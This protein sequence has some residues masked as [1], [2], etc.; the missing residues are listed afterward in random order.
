MN[1]CV[2]YRKLR[3]RLLISGILAAQSA[4]YVQGA[5]AQT[6]NEEALSSEEEVLVLGSRRAGRDVINSAVPVDVISARDIERTGFTQTVELLQSLVPSFSTSKNSITDATDYVRPAQLRGLGPEHVLVLVNG[7][8]RHIS[9]VVHDN[10]Q[11]RGSVNV[12]L[13]SIPPSSIASIEVLRDG[14]AAQYGSDAI[15]GV[16]NINLKK[17]TKLEMGATF[18]SNFSSEDRGYSAGESLNGNNTDASL[19]TSGPG[20]FA[21]D[22]T[23]NP[24]KKDHRD[25]ETAIYHIAKGFEVGAEGILHLSLQYWHQEGSSRNGV[26]PNFQYFGVDPD[27]NLTFD[28]AAIAATNA[29][30]D[31]SNDIRIDP[32]EIGFDRDENW[33]FGKSELTDVSS[34]VNFDLPIGDN[35]TFYTFGGVSRRKGRGPCF[36][37]EPASN[38]NVRSI[39]PDGYLPNV[40]PVIKDTSLAVGLKGN[41]GEYNYDISQTFGHNDFNFKGST[42]NVSLGNDSPTEFDG[43][44]TKFRQLTTNIDITR[45]FDIGAASALNFAFG[46]EYRNE[47]YEIYEGQ[48]EAY[49]NGGVPVL[50]GPNAGATATVGTQCVQ[51][52][53]RVDNIKEGRNNVAFYIDAEVDWTENFTVGAAIRFEDYSDFGSTTTGKLSSRYA[54]TENAGLRAAISTGF[55]AP[56]LQQQFYSNRSLQS[57]PAGNLS[58]TGTFPVNTSIAQALGAQPLEAEESQS[59]SLGYTY[60]RDSFSLTVDAYQVTV[61]DRILLS[62][63]FAGTGLP[64]FL[65]SLTTNP[66]LQGIQRLNYFIN[67]L[68]TTTQGLDV[69]AKYQPALDIN[70]TVDLTLAFNRNDTEID[71]IAE[72]PSQLQPFTEQAI[73]GHTNINNIE[74]AAPKTA[75]HFTIDYQQDYFSVVWRTSYYGSIIAAERFAGDDPVNDQKYDGE[76]IHNAEFSISGDNGLVFSLGANNL[77]DTY[78]DKRFKSQSRW[79]ILPYSGYVPY[80]FTGR[81][82]YGRINWSWDG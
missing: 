41:F 22:W 66:D 68:D 47:Q 14:A 82:I 78:P 12:D 80:G 56:A 23:N 74:Q 50:D 64:E 38:N 30:N 81:Y 63:Q 48:P 25:G 52:F 18:G 6:I 79:G 46:S 35:K 1:K 28:R 9:S 27:G 33:W 70:G 21:L 36:W 76:F 67:G 37:R 19:L 15:A 8:R 58:Q 26:D 32:R 31:P 11:A 42:L 49:T 43:G 73:L 57:T 17:S 61:D 16:I 3:L 7:K 51:S 39:N 29:D 45:S 77:L 40:K 65:D 71:R 62:E 24:S 20:G 2:V 75:S 4:A 55:R 54:L 10:E 60:E 5:W 72:T 59:I 53:H 44:G 34:F 69:I 13:N